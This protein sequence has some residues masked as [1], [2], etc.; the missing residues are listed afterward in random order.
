MPPR[1]FACPKCKTKLTAPEGAAKFRCPKCK[2]VLTPPAPTQAIR[3]EEPEELLVGQQLGGYQVTRLIGSGGMGKV[4][5]AIQAGLKR[6]VALKVLPS[7]AA[8]DAR[9]LTT[10]R[11]E[12]QAVAKLNHPNIV[13][14]FDIIED[15]GH[16][17]FSM[18]FVDG[19]SLAARLEREGPI[20][21][22]D[23][24][25]IL[26]QVVH[27]LD[28]AYEHMLVHRDLKP[29][30]ILV[31]QRGEVKVADLGLSKS[32]EETSV[33]VIRGTHGGPV[34]MA[35]EFA[36]NPQL[37]DCR[38]DI[39]SLGCVLFHL[40]T[41][42]PPFPGPSL[43]DLLDQHA[44]APV[45][46]ARAV[47][48][49]LPESLDALLQ[50][51]CA[52]DPADRFQTYSQLTA[53][54]QRLLKA[55]TIR[56][57]RRREPG[58]VHHYERKRTSRRWLKLV[59]VAAGI[60]VAVAAA[61]LIIRQ[62]G[63][64]RTSANA[65]LPTESK[66]TQPAETPKAPPAET[67]STKTTWP[68][69]TPTK[70]T[71]PAKTPEPKKENQKPPEP[72][73]KAE[74]AK[75][76][77]KDQ[78]KE[79]D[80]EATKEPPKKEEP[81][82]AEKTEDKKEEPKAGEP[83]WKAKLAA[84]QKE[85]QTLA[86][87][88]QFGKAIATLEA[89]SKDAEDADLK[90][91]IETAAAAIRKEAAKAYEAT[92]KAAR[93]LAVE[94]KLT[95]AKAA[96]ETI[97]AQFGTEPEVGNAKAALAALGEHE[98]AAGAIAKDAEKAAA[99]AAAA[100]KRAERQAELAKNLAPVGEALSQWNLSDA[101]AKLEAIQADPETAPQIAPR[102]AAL[103]GALALRDKMIQAIKT[104][105][106]RLRKGDL[107]IPG[108]NGDLTGADDRAIAMKVGE[109]TKKLRWAELRDV[110]LEK[111][112]NRAG[113]Q[114]N[115]ADLLGTAVFLHMLGSEAK[116]TSYLERASRLGAKTDGALDY[117]KPDGGSPLAKADREAK[118]ARAFAEALKLLSANQHERAA[119]AL[120]DYQKEFGQTRHFGEN[121][122]LLDAALAFK[123]FAAPA[124][125]KEPAKEPPKEPTKEPAK[126]PTKEPA[127]EPKKEPPKVDPA[128]VALYSKAAA[129]F[130]VHR[131]DETQGALDELKTK[132]PET[133]LLADAQRK[134][135]SVPDMLKTL[136]SLGDT[137][138][139]GK[140]EGAKR[141]L[142]DALSAL[143]KPNSAIELEA[144]P[145]K[146]TFRVPGAGGQGLTLRAGGETRPILDGVGARKPI[147]NV[148]P[149]LKDVWIE[150]LT[151]RNGE[152]ALSIDVRCTAGIRRCIALDEIDR[153]LDS[154]SSAKVS[155]GLCLFR[156]NSLVSA[157]A[158][159]CAFTCADE[160]MFDSVNLT[161]CILSGKDMQFRDAKLTDCVLLGPA[162]LY[163]GTTLTHVT[164]LGAVSVSAAKGRIAITDSIL[165]SLDAP[166]IDKRKQPQAE[167]ALKSVALSHQPR[168]ILK[169][170]AKAEDVDER[171]KVAF[172]DPTAGD[173]R[174][175]KDSPL[176]EKASDG[177]ELGCRFPQPMAELLQMVQTAKRG[178]ILLHPPKAGKSHLK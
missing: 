18:E 135:I 147:L 166:A 17:F 175:A 111:L 99:A 22:S 83:A 5:E 97:V 85:V 95:E 34:Y 171:A 57:A 125:A 13:Q 128:A 4:Y 161:G 150:G 54:L 122:K 10:F 1:Q 134:P 158:E 80:K 151:F 61:I 168:P 109:E 64:R 44:R 82:A 75:E 114:A 96:L 55:T 70:S 127:K 16:H 86:Q 41:G 115:P 27:A 110:S 130:A 156:L 79:P 28:H 120:A 89:V 154:V 15:K 157:D 101:A 118:A 87:G 136:G 32:L 163:D 14:I 174:L 76:P 124:P 167:V 67:K 176:R 91:A 73:K 153:S 93:D 46:S 106:P 129:A 126:E 162:T 21:V 170:A 35:P 155:L 139:V 59:L 56:F 102:K 159:A 145:Q 117:G 11:R 42:Q 39:Y 165:G 149:D 47:A 8:Q 178:P 131:Y 38:S 63:S 58:A 98:Q 121:K 30:N 104:A 138:K 37:A 142:Q 3:V 143:K 66:K 133:P 90:A 141:S 9:F 52:K 24:M 146:G 107:S 31:G 50:K 69:L 53:E 40:V 108:L 119:T 169:T 177:A 137:L 20:P 105:V 113:D 78:P 12:A 160:A 65:P 51:M 7:R 25:E 45:P 172:A 6:R 74:P 148:G 36:R 140:G 103:D 88:K 23:A 77:P 33:G 84:A 164:V 144:G 94:S 48:P 60:G 26:V 116:A 152:T 19:V 68:T 49:E 43:A 29:S 100:E 92:A 173:W 2:T 72:E 71:E 123:P 81:K 132:F 112:A 62:M